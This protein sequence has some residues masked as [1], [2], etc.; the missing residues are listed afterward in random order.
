[1]FERKILSNVRF[2][3]LCLLMAAAMLAHGQEQVPVLA[4]TPGQS[5]IKF[6]VKASVELAGNF[7][8]WHSRLVFKSTDV[9]TG[10]LDVAIDADSVHT[11]SSMKEHK[12]K[13]KDFLDV[14]EYPL[15]T[16]H[17]DK[18]VQT[19]DNTFD[20]PGTFTLRGISKPATLTFTFTGTRGSG[21]GDVRGT[22]AFDRKDYGMN[23]SIP[24]VTIADRVEVSLDFKVRRISGPPLVFK[25]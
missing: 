20:L 14:K 4:T 11:E 15:I 9:T 12:L 17:S 2:G 10:V 7:E 19:G 13:N 1:M 25:Q 3:V 16:F 24:F 18:I 22:M 21:A 5:T 8:K 6:K 23:K